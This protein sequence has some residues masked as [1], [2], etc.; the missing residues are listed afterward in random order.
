MPCTARALVVLELADGFAR[1]V[2]IDALSNEFADEP[3]V[4]DGFAL[5]LDVQACVQPVID[6]A[7]A[8]AARDGFANLLI[9]KPLR[10]RRCQSCASVSRC[11]ANIFNAVV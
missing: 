6:E 4:A 8:L 10:S 2:A 11:R 3:P 5:A 9:F 1:G 7:V